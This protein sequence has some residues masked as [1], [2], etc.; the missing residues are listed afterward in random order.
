M[1]DVPYMVPSA[2]LLACLA[3]DPSSKSPAASTNHDGTSSEATDSGAAR[4]GTTD[5]A[6]EPRDCDAADPNPPDTREGHPAD[7]WGWEKQG[8]LFEDTASVSP[9]DGDLA[10]TLV[11]TGSEFVMV[12]AR[13]RG[14]EQGLWMSTSTDGISWTPPESV[15]GIDAG[16]IEYPSLVFADGQFHLWHGSGS[17]AYAE[18]TDGR[19]FVPGDTVLRP[20]DAGAFDGVSLL[21]PHA[22]QTQTGIQLFYTGFSGARF[23]I[24]TTESDVPGAPFASGTLLLEH[25]SDGWD[26]TSVGMPEVVV[27][28]SGVQHFWY[29]GYDTIIADPGPWRIGRYDFE[30]GERRVSLPLSEAGVDAWSTRD[31]AVVPHGEGWLMVYVGM[32]D[33]GVYR[34]ARATSRVC[35]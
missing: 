21:Y 6:T 30:T 17:I 7:G 33:D 32:G 25:S 16:S 35:N 2:F 15:T 22:I 14:T 1:S 20:G 18:S 28:S 4:P 12:F 10:P 29:G 19:N 34:L 27:D 3:C 9:G 23:A 11:D 5:T 8:A 13:K 24:G 31:P 26:N